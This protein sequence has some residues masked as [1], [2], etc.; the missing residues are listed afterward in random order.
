MPAANLLFPQQ[1]FPPCS[2]PSSS[3]RHRQ[4][5]TNIDSNKKSNKTSTATNTSTAAKKRTRLTL[6]A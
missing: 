4:L 1:T 6:L 3:K 5:Q 2:K